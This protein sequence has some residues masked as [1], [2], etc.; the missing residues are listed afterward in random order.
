MDGGGD[1][2]ASE[3]IDGGGGTNGGGDA[4][5]RGTDAASDFESGP[6][7][8]GH[9]LADGRLFEGLVP[10]DAIDGVIVREVATI[11]YEPAFTHDILPDSDSRTYV[12]GGVLIGTT[13]TP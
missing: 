2:D 6:A 9:P 12:A 5:G 3:G 13:L 7:N 8:G 1:T 11:P 10:G 4:V